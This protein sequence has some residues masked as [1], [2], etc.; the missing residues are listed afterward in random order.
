MRSYTFN[1]LKLVVYI[2]YEFF[3]LKICIYTTNTRKIRTYGSANMT[4]VFALKKQ[5]PVIVIDCSQYNE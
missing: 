2:R 5:I 1:F 4:L 3:T